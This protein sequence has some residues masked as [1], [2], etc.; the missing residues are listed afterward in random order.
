MTWWSIIPW[1][2]VTNQNAE[3][4]RGTQKKYGVVEKQYGMYS[5]CLWRAWASL[6]WWESSSSC[7]VCVSG[8]GGFLCQSKTRGQHPIHSQCTGIFFVNSIRCCDHQLSKKPKTWNSVGLGL[9]F[10]GGTIGSLLY[11]LQSSTKTKTR[12]PENLLQLVH[13]AMQKKRVFNC[14]SI[15]FPCCSTPRT[16]VLNNKP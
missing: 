5:G 6:S 16:T 2:L 13:D 7:Y 9:S 15:P 4:I 11:A 10:W 1:N 3:I 12:N 8:F 14:C